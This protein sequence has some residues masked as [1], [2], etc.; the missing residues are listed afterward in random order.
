[1]SLLGDVDVAPSAAHAPQPTYDTPKPPPEDEANAAS[2]TPEDPHPESES[3]PIVAH[4][5]VPDG[6][7]ANPKDLVA[8]LCKIIE[9]QSAEIATLRKQ[10]SQ[11]Q[12]LAGNL[13]FL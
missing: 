8:D 5:G 1:M 11:A 10:A 3:V 4:P 9:R 13:K 2:D 7:A 6:T 12:K